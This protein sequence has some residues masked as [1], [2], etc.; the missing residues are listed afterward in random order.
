MTGQGTIFHLDDFGLRLATLREERHISARTMSHDLGQNKNYINGIETKHYLPSL[1]KFFE[2]CD[3]LKVSPRDFFD[4]DGCIPFPTPSE[5][6]PLMLIC[7]ELTPEQA[8][9]VYQ[10]IRNF[11]E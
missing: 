10:M 2:I 6:T 8:D 1:K 5:T 11:L 4:L 9:C 3:Y 7:D